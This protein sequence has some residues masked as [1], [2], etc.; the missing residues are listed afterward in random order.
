[1]QEFLSVLRKYNDF[2]GR[3]T[4][5]EY[6]MFQLIG[7][8]IPLPVVLLAEA[9]LIL[10]GHNLFLVVLDVLLIIYLLVIFVAGLAVLVRRLHDTNRSGW[11]FFI[12]MLPYVGG[13]ILL[14]FLVL[15]SQPGE[16]QYGPNPKE[17]VL[18]ETATGSLQQ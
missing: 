12:S 17:I 6:W 1:M 13:L 10:S 18:N 15:D 14:V 8:L 16:N 4:R 7:F 2:K 11:W 5:K 9:S 3:A